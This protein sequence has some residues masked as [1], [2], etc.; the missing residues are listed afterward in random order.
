M[1]SELVKMHPILMHPPIYQLT[2]TTRAQTSFATIMLTPLPEMPLYRGRFHYPIREEYI[3]KLAHW[4]EKRYFEEIDFILRCWKDPTRGT[5]YEDICAADISPLRA[6]QRLRYKD[7]RQIS[8]LCGWEGNRMFT[9]LRLKEWDEDEGQSQGANTQENQQDEPTKTYEERHKEAVEGKYK[10][11]DTESV[12]AGLG[13][14]WSM[15]NDTNKTSCPPSAGLPPGVTMLEARLFMRDRYSMWA[16][17][18]YENTPNMHE[19]QRLPDSLRCI[20]DHRQIDWKKPEF[21][22]LIPDYIIDRGRREVER[23]YIWGIPYHAFETTR[24]KVGKF[25]ED[26]IYVDSGLDLLL[27]IEHWYLSKSD[28]EVGKLDPD[29]ILTWNMPVTDLAILRS[30]FIGGTLDS[31]QSPDSLV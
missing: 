25:S 21:S 24:R 14:S 13:G 28:E 29:N 6:K 19:S 17:P 16:R 2:L 30:S 4:R 5:F 3:R 23:G 1:S 20:Y 9:G 10:A 18:L 12:E 7:S 31:S 11:D 26:N 8:Q 15:A 22:G 27:R